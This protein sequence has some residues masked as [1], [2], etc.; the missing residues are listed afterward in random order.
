[1]TV[2]NHATEVSEA[3]ELSNAIADIYD[4]AIA[5]GVWQKAL[6]SICAFV[7]GSSAAIFWHDSASVS[8]QALHVFNEDPYFTHLYFDKYV[9]MNPMFPAATFVEEGLVHT[10]R[11]ILPQQELEAT[12]FYKEWIQ[13][14]GIIDA[15][16]VNLEKGIMRSSMISIRMNVTDGLVD[17]QCRRRLQL[18][19]PHL[20]RAVAIGR[21]FDQQDAVRSVLTQTLDHIEAS[22]FLVDRNGQI[23]FQNAPAERLLQD[24]TLLRKDNQSLVAVLPDANRMLHELLAVPEL[25]YSSVGFRG[26]A[27]P[28]SAPA[29]ERWYAHVLPLTS[30]SRQSASGLQSATAAVFVRKRVREAPAPIETLSRLYQ[31]TSS[32]TKVV[33]ALLKGGSIKDM[34]DVL[35]L[36]QATVKTHLQK[37]FQKTGVNRQTELVAL[38]AGFVNR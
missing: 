2:R 26:V 35:G 3:I 15:V 7:G 36:S 5:P 10:S 38:L 34:A 23:L 37:I 8:S 31:L 6:A 32:E 22:V 25:D 14:Q 20:Q 1:M 12:R 27:V 30:G 24:A 17:D 13:P 19:V 9:S 11:D 4:A 21:L 18:L 28:L 16:S 33:D 29:L